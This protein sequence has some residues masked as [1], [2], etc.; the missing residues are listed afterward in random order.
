M[1][2][3]TVNL[4]DSFL[5]LAIWS[6]LT[7][8]RY[9]FFGLVIM[10]LSFEKATVARCFSIQ[11][12]SGKLFLCSFYELCESLRIVNGQVSQDLSVDFDLSLL[13][14]VDKV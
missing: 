12:C 5:Y 10:S 3:E 8:L 6:F 9:S 4:P 1:K 7:S 13:E 11:I 2:P 14:S